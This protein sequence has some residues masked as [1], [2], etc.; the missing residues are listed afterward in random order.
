M[1]GKSKEG[2]IRKIEMNGEELKKLYI[3]L[4]LGPTEIGQIFGAGRETVRRR[5]IELDI[6]RRVA[7]GHK[8]HF[9]LAPWHKRRNLEYL[10]I[11][12]MCSLAEIGRI[13]NVSKSTI[14]DWM[15]RFDIDRRGFGARGAGINKKMYRNRFY[16]R[17]QYLTLGLSTVQIA[18]N[19]GVN[20]TIIVRW[21]KKFNIPRRPANKH[22][23]KSKES[24]SE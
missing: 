5:L 8:D 14:R 3:D 11:E 10:Y 16:L 23:K 2:E 13:Y 6:P 18:R 19:L 21:L 7:R 22:K 4:K 15:I 17:Q 24:C 12:C 1:S 9:I 20:K